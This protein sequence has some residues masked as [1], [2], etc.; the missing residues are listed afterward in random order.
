MMV[1]MVMTTVVVKM[2][3]YHNHSHDGRRVGDG[4]PGTITTMMKDPK[5]DNGVICQ[6]LNVPLPT[7]SKAELSLAR[8]VLHY[9]HIQV[10]I[11][12]VES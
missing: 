12:G 7:S 3:I 6:V 2:M 8:S 4:L 5:R 11:E 9:R 1:M 10:I